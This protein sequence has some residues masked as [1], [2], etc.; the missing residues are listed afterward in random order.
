M[1]P[2][3]LVMVMVTGAVACV[4]GLIKWA[5]TSIL[6]R[7]DRQEAKLDSIIA[8]QAEIR[9][10]CVTWAD[11]DKLMQSLGGLDRRVTVMETTC[12]KEHGK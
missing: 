9:R 8:D 1:I 5:V 12:S 6:K 2:E 3:W 4:G 11:F 10:D 7:L